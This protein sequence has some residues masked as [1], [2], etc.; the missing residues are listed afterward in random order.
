MEGDSRV[1]K[2]RMRMSV[3]GDHKVAREDEKKYK[4]E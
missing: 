2:E 4:I 3:E 1:A